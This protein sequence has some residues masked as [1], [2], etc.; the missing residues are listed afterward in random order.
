MQDLKDFLTLKDTNK[1]FQYLMDNPEKE[2]EYINALKNDKKLKRYFFEVSAKLKSAKLNDKSKAATELKIN[3]MVNSD[4]A[5]EL[6]MDLID[7]NPFQPRLDISD[8]K[9]KE[10]AESIESKGLLQPI[11][12]IRLKNGRFQRILG[13]TRFKAHQYLNRTKI[14]AYINTDISE[15]DE[16]Y[17]SK[18]RLAALAENTDRNNLDPLEIALSYN[19][20]LKVQKT[21]ENLAKAV[22]KSRVYV[23]KVLSVLKLNET[24]L[25]D[26]RVDKTVKDIQALYYLQMIKDE[27]LQNNKYDQLKKGLISRDEVHAF[28]KELT[29]KT[30]K[31]EQS[32][33]SVKLT[34]TK[35]SITANIKNIDKDRKEMLENELN[36]VLKKYL[37]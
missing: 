13:D 5:L 2:T 35:A 8:D 37:G 4:N 30:S 16:D 25:D 36:K 15:D 27:E 22:N 20:E 24:I 3:A 26:L 33:Y 28:A 18:M 21:Q 7:G 12:V 10:M 31:K 11:S 1:M 9:I 32:N 14:K 23:T 29:G 17:E 34:K 6:D 19:E